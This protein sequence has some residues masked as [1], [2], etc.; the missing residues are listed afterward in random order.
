MP[1]QLDAAFNGRGEGEVR[2]QWLPDFRGMF[3]ER[4]SEYARPVD[5][6]RGDR[7][8]FGCLV[9][10]AVPSLF[11]SGEMDELPVDFGE[12][13]HAWFLF[14]PMMLRLGSI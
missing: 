14:F 1:F 5:D 13:G 10:C 9:E 8:A 6:G 3:D 4:L 12:C 2:E 7:F 11:E